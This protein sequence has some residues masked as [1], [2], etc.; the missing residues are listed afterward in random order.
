MST[1]PTRKPRSFT[2]LKS[3]QKK[4]A[5]SRD[6]RTTGK[7]KSFDQK[8]WDKYDGPAVNA[9]L[10]HLDATGCWAQQ[11]PDRFGPDI[12]VWE[13]FR[14]SHY[15]EVEMRTA[16]PG[17]DWPQTWHEVHIPERKGHLYF[18]LGLNCEHWVI[19]ADLSSAL[20]IPDV[21]IKDLGVLKEFRNSKITSGE[22]FYHVPADE[23]IQLSMQGPSA[24]SGM[25]QSEVPRS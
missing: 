13:G 11:N 5:A 18:S 3:D 22:L 15:I 9:V 4:L 24:T 23:C 12:I 25:G 21:V 17:G 2:A 10:D 14:P 16:W 8:S 20:I 7:F 1:P 6:S 19:S